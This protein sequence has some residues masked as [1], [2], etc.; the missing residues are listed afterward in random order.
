ML[1]VRNRQFV[2]KDPYVYTQEG[3]PAPFSSKHLGL[4]L[5]QVREFRQANGIPTGT[6]QELLGEIED[7]ICANNPR[8]CIQTQAQV[9][10]PISTPQAVVEAVKAVAKWV[11]TGLKT[12]PEDVFQYRFNLCQN[13]E[14]KREILRDVAY[15]GHCKCATGRRSLKL[16][17]PFSKC[18]LDP[19]KWHRWKPTE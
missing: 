17:I 18:P 13:C 3:A 19:P 1:R 9:P 11:G 10:A 16:R 4:L 12:V 5:K 6:D 8:I 2:P 14:W 15:C 7:Q